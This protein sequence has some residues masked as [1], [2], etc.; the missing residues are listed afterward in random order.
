[1]LRQLFDPG[2]VFKFPTDLA[3]AL[4]PQPRRTRLESKTHDDITTSGSHFPELPQ[5]QIR[6]YEVSVVV[7]I[8]DEEYH[9]YQ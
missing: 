8:R 1:M 9:K 3:P 2:A 5:E 7:S 4:P 6:K